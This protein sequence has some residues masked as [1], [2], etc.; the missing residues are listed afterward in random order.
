MTRRARIPTLL[1]PFALTLCVL[2]VAPPAAGADGLPILGVDANPVQA[3]GQDVAYVTRR[4]GAGTR[5]AAIDPYTERPRRRVILPG[6]L[7]V[8]AVAYDATPSGLTA[9]GST[10]VLIQPRRR[11]PRANTRF[12]LVDTATLRIRRRLVLRGDFS[13]D[14]LSPDGRLLYLIHYLSPRNP[15]RYEVRA[16]DLRRSRLLERVIVDPREPDERMSGLPVT[17]ATGDGGR[18]EYTLYQGREY[19]FIHALDTEKAEAFCIDLDG[20][21][22]PRDGLWGVKLD[23]DGGNARGRRR[24]AP[25]GQRRHRHSRG[26]DRA[27]ATRGRL[28]TRARAA[29]ERRRRAVAVDRPADA[30]DDRGAGAPVAS[31]R[32]AQL[33][34]RDRG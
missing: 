12:A 3:V 9:D 11:F 32:E 23:L 5:L 16:Y 20:L 14:A 28:G 15:S 10:L 34:A 6:R 18:W 2:A 26:R 7:S 31:G 33:A 29:G 21:A 24:A 8:P 22:A 4:A 13:F 1:T 27:H 19:A 17:R 25:A 30:G